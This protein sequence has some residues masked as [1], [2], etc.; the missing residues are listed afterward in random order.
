M[1]RSGKIYIFVTT[2]TF[3]TSVTF[4]TTIILSQES[5]GQESYLSQE[6]KSPLETHLFKK[7]FW[8]ENSK[9]DSFRFVEVLVLNP[10]V[11]DLEE[12]ESWPNKPKTRT[13][14][15]HLLDLL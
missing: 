2:V 12:A 15:E 1:C 6:Y 3:V 8:R 11:Q 10:N 5:Q 7:W 9:F 4:V 13:L 14:M